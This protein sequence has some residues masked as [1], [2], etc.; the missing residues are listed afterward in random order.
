MKVFIGSV[1]QIIGIIT[2][3]W[4]LMD[5]IHL[6]M[7]NWQLN[8]MAFL[9]THLSETF[10]IIVVFFIGAILYAVGQVIKDS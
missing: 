7:M 3:V 9:T 6:K 8:N 4:N 1:I 2:F 10:I 5:Y